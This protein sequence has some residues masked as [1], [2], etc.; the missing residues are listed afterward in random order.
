MRVT[1]W[2]SIV[3]CL[4]LAAQ[5]APPAAAAKPA[6]TTAYVEIDYAKVERRIAKEPG[7]VAEPRYAM[8][9]FDLAGSHRVWMVAD[10]SQPAAPYYDVLHVDLDGDGDLT[11]A[12]ERFT[13]KLDEKA[14]AAGMAMAIRVGDIRVPGTD[15]VHAKFLVSTAPKQDRSGF[16]FRMYWAGKHEMSGG[17]GATGLDTTTWGASPATAPIFR[18]CPFGPLSFATWGDATIGL[19]PGQLTHVNVIVGNAGSGPNTLAVVDENFLDL[20][21]DELSVTVIASDRDGKP[22]QETTRILKHC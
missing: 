3:S 13:G 16:W 10:K 14:A 12:G 20:E 4:P 22:V 5:A 15:L 21:R 1:S 11:E 17:Y 6:R 18:P 8:F 9:V 19:R 7:Y 2:L